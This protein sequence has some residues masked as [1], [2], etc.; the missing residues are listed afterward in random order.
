MNGKLS[1]RNF[2]ANRGVNLVTSIQILITKHIVSFV[3]DM[4]ASDTIPFES[5]QTSPSIA[6]SPL[7][8]MAGN[9]VLQIS[10]D[11]REIMN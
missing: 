11:V 7:A 8:A 4:I 10:M 1:N 3:G 2:S 9:I 5:D 6:L